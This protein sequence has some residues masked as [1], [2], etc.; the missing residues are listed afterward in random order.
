MD[1]INWTDLTFGD[2]KYLQ[3]R[4]FD[5]KSK[6]MVEDLL[7]IWDNKHS[8]FVLN[9][10]S[11]FEYRIYMNKK[12]QKEEVDWLKL[13]SDIDFKSAHQNEHDDYAGTFDY[14]VD[15]LSKKV[16]IEHG[17]PQ[18]LAV[19]ECDDMGGSIVRGIFKAQGKNLYAVENP[20]YL[21]YLPKSKEELNERYCSFE[22][23]SI[24]EFL[25]KYNEE[26]ESEK[27]L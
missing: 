2:R 27:S 3:D 17:I 22:S 25:K 10:D 21:E 24:D 5:G 15:K 18:Y 20:A 4:N 11:V 8:I 13:K 12:T 1:V 16:K 7:T 9:P 26:N 19:V 6:K 23:K 14:I